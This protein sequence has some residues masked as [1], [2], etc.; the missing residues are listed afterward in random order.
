[1]YKGTLDQCD[2]DLKSHA[3]QQQRAHERTLNAA[4]ASY[5]L[6]KDG[7][8]GGGIIDNLKLCYE[9][10]DGEDGSGIIDNFKLIYEKQDLSYAD[11]KKKYNH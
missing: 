1:M 9:I 6:I 7:E 11:F 5:S 3:D 8:N 2:A 4:V 10:K